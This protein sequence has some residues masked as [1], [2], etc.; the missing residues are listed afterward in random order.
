MTSA[1]QF[2]NAKM[3]PLE[4]HSINANLALQGTYFQQVQEYLA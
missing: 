2:S 4:I 3:G 1:G